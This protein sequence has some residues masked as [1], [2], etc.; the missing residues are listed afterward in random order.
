MCYIKVHWNRLRNR[1][2]LIKR[3]NYKIFFEIVEN[4]EMTPVVGED[5]ANPVRNTGPWDNT[6]IY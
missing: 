3:E 4:Y 6:F 5:D 2:C 1:S